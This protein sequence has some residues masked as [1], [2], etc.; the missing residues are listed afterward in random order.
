MSQILIRRNSELELLSEEEF[1]KVNKSSIINLGYVHDQIKIW[2]TRSETPCVS[3][4][5]TKLIEAGYCN[6]CGAKQ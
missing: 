3:C 4:G 5:K 6:C 2:S 1:E